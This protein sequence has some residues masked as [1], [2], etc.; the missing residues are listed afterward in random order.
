MSVSVII[1]TTGSPEV[2]KAIESVI[3]Q[4]DNV[5]EC[6]RELERRV[7]NLESLG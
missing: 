7:S 5:S 3:Q 1:P 2:I 6:I 4:R